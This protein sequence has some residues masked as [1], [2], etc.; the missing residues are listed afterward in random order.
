MLASAV[1][2]ERGLSTV[3]LEPN[4]QLGKKL[5]ITGN[6]RCNL[7]NNCDINT[8]LDNVVRNGRF[9]HSALNRLSP[10]DT[11]ALFEGLGLR[12]K[13]ESG[14]RVFPA[15]DSSG[16]VVQVL[17]DYMLRSGVKVERTAARRILAEDGAVS[18]V[19]TSDGEMKCRAVILCTGGLSYP[20]TGS[21]GDGYLMAQELGHAITPL[22]PSLVPLV[23]QEDYCREMQGAS[24][25]NVKLTAHD[26]KGRIIFQELGEMIFTHFGISGP[27]ALAA[28]A[29]M[30]DYK[31]EGYWVFI[32]LKP[33]LD[34]SK[35]DDL[36]LSEFDKHRNRDFKNALENLAGRLMIPVLIRLSGIPGDT[37]VNTITREWRRNLVKL[38]KGFP[39]TVAG[40]RPVEE[41]IITRGGVDVRQVC[42]KTMESKLVKGLH[43]A[44]E[45]MDV[46]AYTGGFNLQIAWSTGY[47]AGNSVMQ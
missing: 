30:E 26:G 22:G 33:E 2:A 42:P 39:V 14:N 19:G 18:A 6:G 12:L 25:K 7:T 29:R 47:T 32:D 11:M 28:S 44:G 40:P 20:G 41:A 16:E 35:L 38:L 15:S 37:K 5:R 31:N 21:K 3:L 34:E 1:A 24:L 17:S 13:T 4:R 46:D 43:F 45:I 10:S 36:V 23:S 27:L 8:F 9:L